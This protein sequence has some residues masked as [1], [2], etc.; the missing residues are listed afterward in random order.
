[1]AVDPPGQTRSAQ[2]RHPN[3]IALYPLPEH[4]NGRGILLPATL[5]EVTGTVSRRIDVLV[6]GEVGEAAGVQQNR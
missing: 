4:P 1:M 5:P 3:D 2:R 6:G